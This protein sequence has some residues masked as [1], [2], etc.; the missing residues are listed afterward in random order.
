MRALTGKKG[1]GIGLF[2]QDLIANGSG[3]KQG[4]QLA[5]IRGFAVEF[6]PS[7]TVRSRQA[8]Q[9]LNKYA[10]SNS[11]GESFSLVHNE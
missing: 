2:M 5:K 6:K 8:K 11:S 10:S 9:F 4:T 7:N 3:I 1:T